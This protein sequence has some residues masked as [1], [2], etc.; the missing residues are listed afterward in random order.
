MAGEP[1]KTNKPIA[2]L[3][4]A[5]DSISTRRPAC[6]PNRQTPLSAYATAFRYNL[7]PLPNVD[8]LR[9]TLVSLISLHDVARAEL[10][11]T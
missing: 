10:L 1:R 5:A 2:K 4:H 8:D 9:R 6:S 3:L 11:A 7:S